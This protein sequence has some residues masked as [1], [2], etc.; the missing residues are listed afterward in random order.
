MI[1]KVLNLIHKARLNRYKRRGLQIADDCRLMGMPMFGSE[2]YLISIARRVTISGKVTFITHD[3]G[4]FVFRH[5]PKYRR[6]IQRAAGVAQPSCDYGER[7]VTRS[8]WRKFTKAASASAGSS[9]GQICVNKGA[10]NG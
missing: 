10:K 4:T 8:D 7:L 2:P 5:L 1:S 3:G 6:V 9:G